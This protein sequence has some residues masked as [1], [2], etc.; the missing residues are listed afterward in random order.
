M[1][2]SKQWGKD[3]ELQK[4]FGVATGTTGTW[5]FEYLK[6]SWVGVKTVEFGS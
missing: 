6:E 1:I 5:N 2:S 3:H 4:H